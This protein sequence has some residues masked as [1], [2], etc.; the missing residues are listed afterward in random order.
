MHSKAHRPPSQETSPR[1]LWRPRP[2]EFTREDLAD[3]LVTAKCAGPACSHDRAN[4]LATLGAHGVLTVDTDADTLSPKLIDT[5]LQ[6]KQRG[7][8]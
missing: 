3:A 7:R 4:V 8:I 1:D 6:L 2:G 5:Y